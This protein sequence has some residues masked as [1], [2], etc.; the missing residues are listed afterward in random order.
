MWLLE[1]GW[2]AWCGRRV[3]RMGLGGAVDCHPKDRVTAL[4]VLGL[5]R[6]PERLLARTHALSAD[7]SSADLQSNAPSRKLYAWL[8]L[9]PRASSNARYHNNYAI[10]AR[11]TQSYF[12]LR[13]ACLGCMIKVSLVCVNIRAYGSLMIVT[14][15]WPQLPRD[16]QCTAE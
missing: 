2:L 8:D 13:Q 12:L 7:L 15:N 5:D 11:A 10:P 14:I 1:R 9:N 3:T 6:K 4:I 16:C